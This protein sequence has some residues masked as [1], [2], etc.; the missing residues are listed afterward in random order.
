[1][2]TNFLYE[3]ITANRPS[4]TGT[5]AE[6][7]GAPEPR[8]ALQGTT[9]WMH[10]LA[11][12]VKDEGIDKLSMQA[13]Y[14]NIQ[15]LANLS[16]LAMN[17]VFEQLLMS[18]HH[19]SAL[20]AMVA[21]SSDRDLARVGVMTWYYGIY[22]AASA[23]IAAKDGS[24]QQDHSG[25]ATQWDR[26]IVQANLAVPPF[27][28]RL[29]S[30]VKKEAMAEIATLRNNNNFSLPNRPTNATD[31]R[32]ACI[33]YLSGTRDYLEWQVCEILRTKELPK[34]GVNNFRT[35][36]AQQLRDS[37]L[38]GKSLGFVHQAFRYRGKA[39]YRDALFLTY[40]AQ[41][42]TVLN[43]FIYDMEEVLKAFV[44]MAGAFCAKR[45]RSDHWQAFK[46]DLDAH[47][48]LAVMPND[49]WS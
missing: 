47:L 49:V 37:R 9:N 14:N 26:Q 34:L 29:S 12:V 24:Q 27:S 1:M 30:L 25:T 8:F 16:E 19:L 35:A 22:C 5:L 28:Y 36:N 15:R 23:M 45:V 40:E 11:M 6:P 2:A 46:A 4:C 3:R 33:S 20:H 41:V 13:K 44:T 17:T 7:N 39:N 32:G 10:A 43:G 48:A 18:L 21:A 38:Q 31:A 42:G